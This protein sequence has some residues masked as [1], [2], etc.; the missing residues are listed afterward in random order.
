MDAVVLEFRLLQYELA[1]ELSEQ[2]TQCV[3]TGVACPHIVN[4]MAH[5]QEHRLHSPSPR[6]VV[7]FG[8]T[9]GDIRD[10][11]KSL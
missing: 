5:S 4:A 1:H 3:H 8:V 11:D 6:R 7:K 10:T 9:I 2:L